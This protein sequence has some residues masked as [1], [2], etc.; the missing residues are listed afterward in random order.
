MSLDPDSRKRLKEKLSQSLT[1]SRDGSIPLRA[2]AWA[3]RGL[4]G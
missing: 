2:R 1:R 3:L 4:V